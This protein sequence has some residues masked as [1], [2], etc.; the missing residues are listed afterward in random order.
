M[1]ARVSPAGA[2]AAVVVGLSLMLG[3]VLAGSDAEA[4]GRRLQVITSAVYKKSFDQFVVPRM[5]EMYGVEVVASPFLSAETLAKAIAQK[6]NPQTSVF[7]LDEGPW[8]QGKE[9]GLWET[10]DPAKVPNMRDVPAQFADK[11]HRGTP[12]M[13]VMLGLMYEEAALKASSVPIPVSF[14]DMWSPAFRNR[15]SIQQFS[16]TFAFALLAYTTRLEGG[17]VEKSFDAG[18]AKL[19][20]LRPNV[21]TF[22]GPAAQLIQLFQQKEIWLAWGGHFSAMQAAAAG[23]PVRWIAPKEGAMGYAHFMAIAKGAPNLPDA[24]RLVNLMLSPEYQKVMAESDFMGPVNPKTR[25]GAE[26]AKTFPVTVQA[27]EASKPI[28]WA[29]YNRN[30]VMLNERWQREIEQ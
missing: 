13:L 7:M 19:K 23:A 17:D 30:R 24:E 27:V 28:P 26:F 5:K 22:S 12:L 16:S 18:F 4:Q 21:R 10:L 2:F 25:L 6:D 14:Y 9:A 20:Q 3:P 11:D 15:V 1:H 29:A 8:L